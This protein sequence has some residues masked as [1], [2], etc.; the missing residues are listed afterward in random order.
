MTS[1]RGAERG[2]IGPHSSDSV[3]PPHVN[4]PAETIDEEWAE[5]PFVMP[6][7]E[8]IFRIRGLEKRRKEQ[9]KLD[10][11]LPVADKTTFASRMAAT[12]ASDS[13]KEVRILWYMLSESI[14]INEC[15][16]KQSDI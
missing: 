4:K 6:D 8:E 11:M 5:E 15:F 1:G 10:N 14:A 3:I 13:L 2:A 16:A 12:V 7:D 9:K